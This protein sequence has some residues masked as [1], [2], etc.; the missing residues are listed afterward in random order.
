M[1]N[2]VKDEVDDG[3]SEDGDNETDDGIENGVFRIG[4]FFIV[5]AGKD[6]AQA[7]PNKHN[8]RNSPDDIEGDVG[9]L[10]EDAVGADEVFWHVVGTGGFGAFTDAE[11]HSFARAERDGGADAGEH[12]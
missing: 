3:I 6:V 5:A 4:D 2:S 1:V 7:A 12:L 9:E 10:G 8:D 11:R